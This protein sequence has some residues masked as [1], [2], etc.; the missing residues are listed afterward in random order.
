M[1]RM[2]KG[3][4]EYK[5]R[6]PELGVAAL[7]AKLASTAALLLVASMLLVTSSY[8]WFVLSTAPEVSGI[9]TQVGANGSLEVALLNSESWNDLS[10]LDRGDI[11]ESAAMDLGN[12][13]LTWGNLVDLSNPAYGLSQITLNPARLYIEQSGTDAN[14]ATSYAVNSTLLKTPIYGEDGRVQSLDKTSAVSYIYSNRVFGTEGYGVRAIGTSASLSEFARGLMAGRSAVGTATSAARTAASNALNQ[15]GGK[16]ADIVVRYALT[17]QTTGYTNADVQAV[18]D[19]AEGLSTALDQIETAIRQTFAGYLATSAADLNREYYRSALSFV[20]N[21]NNSLTALLAQYGGIADMVSGMSDYIT[22]IAND[23]TT[24]AGAIATCNT[25][26]SGG[27]FSW[28]QIAQVVYPLMDTDRMLIG[29]MSI[30][31][32]KAYVM[33]GGELNFNNAMALLSG[34]GITLTVPTGSGVL[35]DIADFAG[36]YTAK[37]TVENFSYGSI[38]PMNVDVNMVTATTF[39]PTHLG[40]C[41]NAMNHASASENGSSVTSITDFYGYAIDLALRTNAVESS[42]LLQTEPENRVYEGE[43]HSGTQGGGSYMVFTTQ[44]GLSATKMVKLMQGIRVVFMDE[45]RTVLAIAA[46]DC[47]LGKDVYVELSAE[48]KI[49]TGKYAYLNGSAS[50]YQISDLIDYNTYNALAEES[51]VTFDTLNNNVYARLY[52]YS[53]EMTRSSTSTEEETK[54]TGGIT[55]GDIQR[56]GVITAMEQDEVRRVTA[57][58]Y[59]DGSY[60]TNANVAA[61]A[62]QSMTGKLN[63]QFSSD[64]TLLPAENSQLRNTEGGTAGNLRWTLT[65]DGT[66]T[67]SGYGEMTAAPWLGYAEDIRTVVIS[68]GVTSI[69]ENAFAGC[70]DLSRVT[71]PATVTS[72]ATNAFNGVFGDI[73]GDL[74]VYYTGT[75]QAWDDLTDGVYLGHTGTMTVHYENG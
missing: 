55:L 72:I 23:Q 56:S 75:P 68:S 52:L 58:V 57:L 1:K 16:L 54:Y 6:F 31:E 49:A 22:K 60:V 65:P 48:E 47:K 24:V 28:E 17:N 39:N 30:E 69:S 61:N 12:A 18:K 64:A 8:A 10:L 27:S 25:M 4:K 3:Y 14:G 13:N 33:P 19:M 70:A 50:S 51:S 74:S 21:E 26:M 62:A 66:L 35:S 15:Q 63:L 38:G 29:G 59:I 53:F 67:I 34:G 20:N 40:A 46:L 36:N 73:Q 32:A 2:D 42:L 41:S 9:D 7:K 11:D 5:R 45:N 43:T 37:V 44:A 71:I